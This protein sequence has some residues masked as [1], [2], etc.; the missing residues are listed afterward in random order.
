M[1]PSFA[2]ISGTYVNSFLAG[3]EALQKGYDE[4]IMLNLDGTVAEATGMNV[5][6]VKKGRIYTPPLSANILAGITRDSVF[7]I[8]K[9]E[10]KIKAIEKKIK[11][12]DL[13]S[14]DEVFLTGTGSEVI[15]VGSIDGKKI[16]R[17]GTGPI[18]DTLQSLY[19][20]IVRGEKPRY[21]GWLTPVF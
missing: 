11:P 18:T 15:P 17:V 13:K 21:K 9:K 4:S 5:F 8:A 2:K 19:R 1:I 12:E 20:V 6:M 16:G 3:Q 7:R 14:A 10:L